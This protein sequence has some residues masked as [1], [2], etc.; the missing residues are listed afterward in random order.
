MQISGHKNLQSVRNYSALNEDKHRQISNVL[1]NT[2]DTPPDEDTG[3]ISVVQYMHL[4]TVEYLGNVNIERYR[5]KCNFETAQQLEIYYQVIWY[6][7]DMFHALH[8]VKK[9]NVEDA[10]LKESDLLKMGINIKC[11]V[12]LKH[13]P[14]STPG[15]TKVSKNQFYGLRLDTEAISVPR[16]G[17]GKIKVKLTIPLGCTFFHNIPMPCNVVIEMRYPEKTNQ[18]CQI[19]GDIVGDERL[20]HYSIDN[21]N[22]HKIHEIPVRWQDVG[23]NK[24]SATEYVMQLK[25][26]I[27]NPHSNIW[28]K[29]TDIPL[30]KVSFINRK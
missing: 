2:T 25:L 7:D 13:K 21:N 16:S 23:S 29:H 24:L 6:I 12:R 9:E 27:S 4:E 28:A 18:N 15:L 1:S 17:I 26:L 19:N 10:V 3:E 5:F 11:S 30:I 8:I 20:C 14:D 22:W